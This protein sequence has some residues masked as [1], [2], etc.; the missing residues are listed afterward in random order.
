[1]LTV[2]LDRNRISIYKKATVTVTSDEPFI[3]VEARAT[4]IGSNFGKGVGED[5]LSDDA[6]AV[7]GVVT[8][9]SAVTSYS[10]DVECSELLTD[11]EYRISVYVMNEN[12]TWDESYYLL[13]SSGQIVKDKTGSTICVKRNSGVTTE[14]YKSAYSGEQI[15][16]FVNEVLK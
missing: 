3:A 12:G 11:G 10:F 13:T 2:T 1:M 9:P 5:L 15:N 14:G 8:L 16:N 4:R 6:T 7:N